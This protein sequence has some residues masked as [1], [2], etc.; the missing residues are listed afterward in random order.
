MKF[1]IENTRFVILITLLI[2]F[3]G[4]KGLKNLQK[5]SI[6]P[7]DFATAIIT[8]IYPGSSSQEVEEL[9]TKKIEDKI[10]TVAHL[11]DVHSISQAGWSQITIR[12]D[13][14]NA[15]TQ[16][17]INE[18]HQALQ[19]V[20]GL[21]S[22]VLDPPSLLHFDAT[23]GRPIIAINV[24]G[25]NE[26]R[27]KDKEAWKLKNKIE[28]LEGVLNVSLSYYKKREFLIS[29][30]TEKMDRWYISSHDVIQAVRSQSSD[31]PAGSLE[32]DKKRN[33]T[34][35]IGNFRSVEELENRVVR[36]NFSGQSIKIKDIAEVKD[37]FEKEQSKGYIYSSELG[38]SFSLQPS[39]SLSVLKNI[40][41]DLINV[42][43]NIKK[44]LKLSDKGNKKTKESSKEKNSKS[45]QIKDSNSAQ[46]KDSNS[47]QIKDS[48]SAQIKDSK[49]AQIKDSKSAQLKDSNSAQL[50]DSNSSS[51]PASLL[52][53]SE[54]KVFISFDG[55][56][57]TKRKL[58]NVI[59]NTVFGLFLIFLIFFMF[60][61]SR[62]GFLASFSL[63]LSVLA[64][65]TFMPFLGVSFNMITML[66][67]VICIGMLVDNSVVISEYYVRLTSNENLSPSQSAKQVVQQ[68]FKPITATVLT[69]V[70]VFLPMLITKG[71]M[72]EFIKWIPIV[73]S[74]AL[75]ISLFE[76]FC[77]LPNRLQWLPVQKKPSFYQKSVLEQFS[78][79][80]EL[81]SISLKYC[82]NRKYFSLGVMVF[83]LV[84]T[85]FLFK[86]RSKVDLFSSRTP[87]FYSVSIKFKPNLPLQLTDRES[88][89]IAEKVQAVFKGK[90][91][92]DIMEVNSNKSTSQILIQVKRSVLKKL[93]YQEILKELRKIEKTEFIKELDFL[94]MKG[95]PPVG[96]ALNI[97]F[98]SNDRQDILKFIDHV[99]PDISKIKGLL[100][101]KVDPDKEEGG[102]EYK[103]KVKE[104]VLAQL[105]LSFNFVGE[106]LRTALEGSILKEMTEKNESFYIRVRH[107]EEEMS[108][109]SAIKKIKVKE[110]MGRQISLGDVVDIKEQV[111]EPNRRT[112]NFSPVLFL[113][114]GVDQNKSTSLKINHQA[115]KIIDREIGKFPNISYKLIGERE[116]TSESLQSLF[117]ASVVAFFAVLIILVILFKSF[118]LSFLV[119]SCV[120]LGLI[121]VVWSFVLHGRSLTFF[122]LIG[123]V[124]L[125]GVVV[126]SAIILISFILKL[127]QEKPNQQ[128]KDIVISASKIRLRPILITNLTTLGGLLPTAYGFPSFEPLLMP[129]T[130]ALFWGLL[131]ASLLTLFWV[132]CLY[133]I[134]E[135]I[136]D[137]FTR[138]IRHY[139]H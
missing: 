18:L 15:D 81:F 107:D 104:D 54:P 59:N 120:P 96:K 97:A 114:A 90:E 58:R 71:V 40:N 19:N 66:A 85:G 23:R 20:S 11:K 33:L 125:A 139:F 132:P 48:K 6:P 31:L 1:F 99:F 24:V 129:M 74:L 84:S 67:F 68:F 118:I 93:K 138:L 123:V 53:K 82:L 60:L 50:K 21:P 56:K 128:L 46:I 12:I 122:A 75:L 137:L 76:S 117:Q 124:G 63:P 13:M 57:D 39:I 136:K 115:Q 47:A 4:I 86:F 49:S 70:V 133:L 22:E 45:A 2:I 36:S 10:R 103:I 25:S 35:L 95:G 100:N 37:H 106:A 87:E 16:E 121:G 78:K 119:L 77:L 52:S 112:Y 94:A 3:M 83:L 65:L 111:A 27:D 5:E 69:T 108:S 116:T 64:V 101:V 43:E 110:L 61:P 51:Q 79:L 98:L 30:S 38:D 105:G 14:D 131:S 44:K 91:N 113:Q 72:G 7:V 29:L 34:R 88:L 42:V 80:E 8:T 28:A 89:K 92:I 102:T 55:S 109:L 135:D 17:V 73:V 127:R 9:I 134:I 130:L 62:V 126:N 32:S 41:A 26:N